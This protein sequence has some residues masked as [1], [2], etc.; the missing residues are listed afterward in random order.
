[1]AIPAFGLYTGDQR[2]RRTN[3]SG[4][5]RGA[6]V[7]RG[8]YSDPGEI[9]EKKKELKNSWEESLWKNKDKKG[10][11]VGHS[12]GGSSLEGTAQQTKYPSTRR[13]KWDTCGRWSGGRTLIAQDPEVHTPIGGVN[14]GDGSHLD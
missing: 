5:L 7:V 9:G 3:A 2:Q 1:M 4:N 6:G 10:K 11:A 8:S 14:Y 13:G 12:F